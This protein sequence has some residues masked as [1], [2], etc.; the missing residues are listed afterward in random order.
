VLL[1]PSAVERNLLHAI[2]QEDARC[3]EPLERENLTAV[4][5]AT[6]SFKLTVF[7]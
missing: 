1:T 6:K 2:T 3:P 5:E 4:R 7:N